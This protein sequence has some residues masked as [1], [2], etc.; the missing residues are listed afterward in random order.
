[1]KLTYPESVDCPVCEGRGVIEYAHVYS[2]VDGTK[3]VVW[4]LSSVIACGCR[5]AA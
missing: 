3:T 1:M 5:S 2:D 4:E